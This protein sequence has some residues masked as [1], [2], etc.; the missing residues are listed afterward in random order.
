MVKNGRA[1]HANS[2]GSRDHGFFCVE[3]IG[4][5]FRHLN[6]VIFNGH[7]VGK[8]ATNVNCEHNT[9]LLMAILAAINYD[10]GIKG[11]EAKEGQ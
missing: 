5:N 6:G 2:S 7:Y 8:C 4:W 9:I 3:R 10:A 11:C 1:R